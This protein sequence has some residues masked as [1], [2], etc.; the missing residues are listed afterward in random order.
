M[1]KPNTSEIRIL[2]ELNK[3]K[4]PTRIRWKSTEEP[5]PQ[6]SKAMLLSLFEKETRDTYKIDLWTKEMQVTEMDR[7]M[8][9]TLRGLA[10]TY[11]TA[12]NNKEL[13]Q[14]MRQFVQYFGEQTEI[15]K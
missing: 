8:Y 11:F 13:A 12:T 3:E 7:M 9:Q 2:I 5:T 6:E 14:E 1:A 4:V 15:V 10:D